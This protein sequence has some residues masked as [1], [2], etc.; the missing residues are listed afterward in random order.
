MAEAAFRKG[1]RV[2]VSHDLARYALGSI[3]RVDALPPDAK[4]GKVKGAANAEKTHFDV[5]LEDGGSVTVTF[6][7]LVAVADA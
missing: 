5:D 4:V 6:E 1:D 3:L 2:A 7:E